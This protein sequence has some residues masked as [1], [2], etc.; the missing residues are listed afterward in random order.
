MLEERDKLLQGK[1]QYMLEQSCQ[2]G[3]RETALLNREQDLQQRELHIA[4][5]EQQYM[6]RELHLSQQ[7][8]TLVGMTGS[9]ALAA[10]PVLDTDELE[11]KV[12]QREKVIQL[13]D[14]IINQLTQQLTQ[15]DK[16]LQTRDILLQKLAHHLKPEE[17]A[18]LQLD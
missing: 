17:Q 16:A 14:T 15:K 6:R 2:M 9:G 18:Q 12:Q 10:M 4:E 7:L 1:D 11:Q 3:E 13:K 5:R 8:E